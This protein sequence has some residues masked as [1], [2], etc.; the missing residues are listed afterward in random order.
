MVAFIFMLNYYTENEDETKDEHEE[1]DN[2]SIIQG[3]QPGG[4]KTKLRMQHSVNCSYVLLLRAYRIGV[5]T[6]AVCVPVHSHFQTIS[7]Q[8][9]G[10]FQS[11]F[12]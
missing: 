4:I 12:I 8:P 9:A 7:L 11:N 2:E 10:Q 1:G 5:E 6:A 3:M